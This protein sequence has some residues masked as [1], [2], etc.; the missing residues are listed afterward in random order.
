[1]KAWPLA[2]A[3]L[4]LAACGE[5]APTITLDFGEQIGLKGTVIRD[6]PKGA[7]VVEVPPP[8]TGSPAIP[9]QFPT[10]PLF[11]E[12]QVI[13]EVNG[14]PIRN[15]AHFRDVMNALIERAQRGEVDPEG[16]LEIKSSTGS[17]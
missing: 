10:N 15:A 7:E 16:M 11:Q 12:G 1:M 6:H 17:G 5:P 13:H 8:A 3:V 4:C 14:T 9:G 2:A